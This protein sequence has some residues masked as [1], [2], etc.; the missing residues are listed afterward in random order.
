MRLIVQRV[1]QA[2][3]LVNSKTIGS[4]GKG[5][6]VLLGVAEKDTEKEVVVLAEK[7][8]KLRVMSDENNKMNLS[9]K[10]VNGEVLVVSQFTLY[11]DTSK[12]NRPS[13]IKVA[14]PKLAEKLY[15][16]FIDKLKE[17]GI[18]VA[19]GEFGAYM[20]IKTELDGPVTILVDSSK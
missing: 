9:V 20:D 10:D 18:K 7:L 19:T 14:K 5:L 2:K 6:F 15:R 8:A 4:I 17:G 11:A 3:V 1:S 12:G 16:L 13:F